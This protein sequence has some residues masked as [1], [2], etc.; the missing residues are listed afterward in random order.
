MKVI[1]YAV[2]I[3]AATLAAGGLAAPPIAGAAPCQVWKLQDNVL[4]MTTSDGSRA[5]FDWDP[6]SQQVTDGSMTSGGAQW[7]TNYA[8]GK[9]QG[10]GIGIN[11]AWSQQEGAFGDGPLTTGKIYNDIF[12][13]TIQPDGQVTGTRLD[14]ANNSTTWLADQRFTCADQAAAPE[15]VPD[16][17][18]R[19]VGTPKD[20]NAQKPAATEA[21]STITADVELYDVPGGGGTYLG[22]VAGGRKVKVLT[23]QDDNWVQISGTGVANHDTGWVWGDFVGP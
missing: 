21:T 7:S 23:R 19:G 8:V 6:G 22:D 11:V 5:T 1:S 18:I 20:P 3:A 10:T 4:S 15:P 17:P 14:S 13:G 16:K 12:Q 2:V 9:A